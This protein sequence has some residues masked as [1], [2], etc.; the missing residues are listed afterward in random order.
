MKIKITKMITCKNKIL[1]HKSNNQVRSKAMVK[2][3]NKMKEKVNKIQ[4]A[5]TKSKQKKIIQSLK[6]KV[7]QEEILKRIVN[8]NLP[9]IKNKV[10]HPQINKKMNKK[11]PY[12]NQKILKRNKRV[13]YKVMDQI[14]KS[15]QNKLQ[16]NRRI[17]IL[18][19]KRKVKINQL[20]RIKIQKEEKI[21]KEGKQRKKLQ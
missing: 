20:K 1:I 3:L 7:R 14:L 6:I 5:K 15:H 16:K 2:I 4:V 12:K 21:I 19:L 17:K 9:I 10:N 11:V 8:N 18:K 13:S